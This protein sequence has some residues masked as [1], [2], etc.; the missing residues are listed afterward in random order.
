MQL[1]LTSH[2][3]RHLKPFSSNLDLYHPR[4]FAVQISRDIL[5]DP[6]A[7]K[8]LRTPSLLLPSS[9]LLALLLVGISH[10]GVLVKG[11]P[12]NVKS[13]PSK[14]GDE[15]NTKDQKPVVSSGELGNFI[16]G[17][18]LQIQ[19]TPHSENTAFRREALRL[20]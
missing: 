1:S 13:H 11:G 14:C 7:S 8:E 17:L 2:P 3:H 15:D 4:A 20:Q 6:S 5:K 9:S 18:C 16:G 10:V 12:K 19:S